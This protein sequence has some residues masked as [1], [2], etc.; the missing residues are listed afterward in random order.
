L[1]AA[2]YFEL[3]DPIGV[4][5]VAEFLRTPLPEIPPGTRGWPAFPD[6]AFLLSSLVSVTKDVGGRFGCLLL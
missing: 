6:G 1:V 5:L 4:L 2:D 3:I